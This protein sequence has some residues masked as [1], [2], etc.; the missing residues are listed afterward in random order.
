MRLIRISFLGVLLGVALQAQ[1]FQTLAQQA[2]QLQQTGNY[3][4]AEDVYRKLLE[5][6]PNQVA[7][8]VN[9]AI[10]MVNLGQFDAAIQQY[11][12]AEKL[13][14][15]DPRIEM[16]LGLAY[17][18]SGR[19]EAACQTF[20]QL[21]GSYPQEQKVTVLLAD[22]SLQLGNDAKVIDLLT[23]VASQTN[24]D[25]AISYMLGMALLHQ[26]RTEEAQVQLD[27]ILKNGATAESHF[28]LGTRAFEAADYPEAAKQFA[29]AAALNPKLP[30]L[31]SFLGRALLYT[32][33]PESA[34]R[35]FRLELDSNPSD[36]AANLGLA[37]ILVFKK[38][39]NAAQPFAQRAHDTRPNSSDAALALAQSLAGENQFAAARPLGEQAEHA[40]PKSA[41]VHRL[42]AAIY[43]GLNDSASAN[44]ETRISGQ[45]ESQAA[46][47]EPGPKVHDLAPDFSLPR[48]DSSAKV[49]LHDFRGKSPVVLVF[50]S[51]TCP[52]F[53]DSADALKELQA[54][55]GRDIP[56]L[57][58]Y[59]REA[60]S[61]TDWQSTRNKPGDVVLAQATDVQEKESHAMM[62]SRKLHLPFPAVVDG[63]DD[64]VESAYAAWP[65]RVFIVGPDGR[66]AYS[67]RLTQLDFH[68]E[69]MEAVLRRLSK[70]SSQQ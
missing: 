59:I 64:A 16:N 3:A 35:A 14:P 40:L 17:E 12:Q 46:A 26:H 9:L 66:I 50:G 56:F 36:F 57:L 53:R 8:H 67:T 49:S 11:Q 54:R 44:R 60:H 65:S 15:G 23:P 34:S 18:K 43:T 51:Y 37:Q 7:T 58:V 68:P 1:D 63:M 61:A 4:A 21:H 5:L 69:A 39:Y 13:L 2:M 25:L 30:Q 47:A 33:D 20:D 41:E 29:G 28:L 6:D 70:E 19:L 45:L 52:N 42:M 38:D 31:Q 27:R 10:V 55:Y 32:G 22:C 24:D 62:C 48:S